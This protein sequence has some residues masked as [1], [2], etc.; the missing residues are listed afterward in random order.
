MKRVVA[1]TQGN[2]NKPLQF[3]VLEGGGIYQED[4]SYMIGCQFQDGMLSTQ[5]PI[6]GFEHNYTPSEFSLWDLAST[7]TYSANR[8]VKVPR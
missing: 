3:P 7:D 4:G 6:G 1:I 8:S 5:R 2:K